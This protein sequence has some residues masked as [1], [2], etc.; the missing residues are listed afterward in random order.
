MRIAGAVLT[1]IVLASALVTPAYATDEDPAG[2]TPQP[3][4][5]APEVPGPGDESP[6]PDPTPEPVPTDPA[7]TDPPSANPGPSDS[8]GTDQPASGGPSDGLSH[9][10]TLPSSPPEGS[11]TGESPEVDVP[12]WWK[13]PTID[14]G[15]DLVAAEEAREKLRALRARLEQ[16]E[17]GL[18]KAQTEAETAQRQAETARWDSLVA[19]VHAEQAQRV[20]DQHA[21]GVYRSGAGVSSL[22][23]I[24]D[25]SSSDPTAVLDEQA[26]LEQ[27][28]RLRSS[29]VEQARLIVEQAA[30]LSAQ[31]QEAEE[32][33]SEAV[34]QAEAAQERLSERLS[35]AKT[36]LQ[37]VL[38]T[39][40]GVQTLIGPNGCPLTVPDGTLRG[41]AA[42]LNPY[43]LCRRSVRAAATPEAALAIKYLFRALGAPY[44]C[45]G[46][47]RTEP[48]RYDCSSLAARAY[49]EGA[50]MNTAGPNWSPSTRDMVPW[51]GIA[52]GEHYYYV[53]PAD[54]RPGDLFLYDT[55]GATYRHVVI[56]IADGFMIHTN[57]CGDVA[58]VEPFWGPGV[59]GAQFLVA[60]RV[61]TPAQATAINA[62]TVPSADDTQAARGSQSAP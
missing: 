58:K 22:V 6:A 25:A 20:L 2:P 1:G 61:L 15:P 47:G 36:E 11:T 50:G 54:A 60:R 32:R 26:W 52:L 51:D 24:V 17:A 28:S 21:S 56:L 45:D 48:Y 38:R 18:A 10:D 7:P 34:V 8:P 27:A 62:S 35:E 19:G 3:S 16:A 39:P 4:P 42:E 46:V 5:S 43:D 29:Q 13:A 41:P 40:V 55:G 49:A 12:T 30:I 57:A 53:D 33:A 14:F 59:N 44:A 23:R 31:A 9:D 37:Q